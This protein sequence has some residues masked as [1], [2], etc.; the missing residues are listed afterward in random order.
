M[1]GGDIIK[2][3]LSIIEIG[4]RYV[5]DSYVTGSVITE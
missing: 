5:H 3:M 1:I 4:I 2:M